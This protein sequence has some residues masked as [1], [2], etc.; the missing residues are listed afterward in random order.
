MEPR[1]LEQLQTVGLMRRAYFHDHLPR[2]VHSIMQLVDR[3]GLMYEGIYRGKRYV[4]VGYV[5]SWA[6]SAFAKPL[7]VS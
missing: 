6:G 4:C 5:C 2:L 1:V 3:R 7:H